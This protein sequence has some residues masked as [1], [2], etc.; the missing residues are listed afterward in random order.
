MRSFLGQVGGRQVD[1][2]PLGRQRQADGG[3]R[4]A[5]PLAAFGHRLVGQSYD[6]EIGET[7]H[8]LALHLDGPRLQ[9]QIGDRRYRCDQVTPNSYSAPASLSAAILLQDR[10]P[11]HALVHRAA[12]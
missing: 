3:N 10:P 4:I 6:D 7:W 5:H 9:P 11:G 8:Q 12:P 2:N 1:G